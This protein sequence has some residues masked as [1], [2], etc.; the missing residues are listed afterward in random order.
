MTLTEFLLARIA[1]EEAVAR[2]VAEKVMPDERGRAVYYEQATGSAAEIIWD[3]DYAQGGYTITAARV[4]AECEAK[5]RIVEQYDAI[6][7]LQENLD[8]DTRGAY[9]SIELTVQYLALPYA[10][11]PDYDEAWRP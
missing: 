2:E 9:E 3:V 4:L 11:H 1:E 6:E 8:Y 5:R 7:R 10:D